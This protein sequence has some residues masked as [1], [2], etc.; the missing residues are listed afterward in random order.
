MAF[1][2]WCAAFGTLF[3]VLAAALERVGLLDDPPCDCEA[4]AHAR[5]LDVFR[6]Y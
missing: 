3:F 1:L 5:R 2:L 4:C 6:G